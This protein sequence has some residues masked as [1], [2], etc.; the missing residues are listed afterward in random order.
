MAGVTGR[1]GGV[2]V[3]VAGAG[4]GEDAGV[5]GQVARHTVP[6][7]PVVAQTGLEHDGRRAVAGVD[8]L[9]VPTV[10]AH[11][12]RFEAGAGGQEE[13]QGEGGAG[14]ECGHGDTPLLGMSRL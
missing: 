8:D 2:A 14:D 3:A 4:I 7:M 1:G 9:D 10:E 5:V 6:V 12:F 11:Y 13:G